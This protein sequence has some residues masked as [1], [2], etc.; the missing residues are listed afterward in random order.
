MTQ[1]THKILHNF[2]VKALLSDLR[3]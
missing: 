2:T 3:Q 1:T